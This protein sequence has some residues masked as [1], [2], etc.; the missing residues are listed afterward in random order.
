MMLENFLL[1]SFANDQP[2]LSIIHKLKVKGS[3]QTS[4]KPLTTLGS[5]RRPVIS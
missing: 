5:R 1:Y 3:R 4:E 2:I